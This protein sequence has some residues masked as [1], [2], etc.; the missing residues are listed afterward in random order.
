MRKQIPYEKLSKRE[1]RA[2]DRQ[3]RGTWGEISPVTRKPANP[4]AYCRPKAR[5]WDGDPGA[6]P[7]S[8]PS[9]PSPSAASQPWLRAS[10]AIRSIRPSVTRAKSSCSASRS[11]ARTITVAVTVAP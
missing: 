3:R 7:F 10:T 2:L 4:R 6:A 8:L 1:K 11:R 5:R 9:Y